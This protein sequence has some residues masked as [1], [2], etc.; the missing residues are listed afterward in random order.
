MPE[1]PGLVVVERAADA[2]GT[3]ALPQLIA[4]AK[5]ARR[6]GTLVLFELETG[7]AG[8]IW[9]LFSALRQPRWGLTLQPDDAE[10]QTPFREDLGRVRR[11]DF[12][13][14]RGFAIEAGR[15]TPIHVA[16]P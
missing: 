6:S 7:S 8:G 16:L 11:A 12:P 14:G 13:P 1:H 2:E 4:L 3:A 9:E 5:A 10:A 15:V